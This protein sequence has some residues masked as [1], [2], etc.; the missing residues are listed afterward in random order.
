MVIFQSQRKT[1]ENQTFVF[2]SKRVVNSLK[3]Q[4]TLE[5][6]AIKQPKQ[7]QKDDESGIGHNR[8]LIKAIIIESTIP[9]FFG[10]F[11]SEKIVPILYC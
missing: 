10:I 1:Q 3:K 2:L 4:K 9:N 7:S 5:K 11:L 8:L 6:Q